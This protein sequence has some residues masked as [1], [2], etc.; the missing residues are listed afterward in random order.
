EASQSLQVGRLRLLFQQIATR[1]QFAQR[2]GNIPAIPFD[3]TTHAPRLVTRDVL[4]T[5][6]TREDGFWL[7]WKGDGGGESRPRGRLDGRPGAGRSGR[8]PGEPCLE[9]AACPSPGGAPPHEQS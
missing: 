5:G 1:R 8:G 3:Y 7:D 2:N 4:K 6:H 9:R